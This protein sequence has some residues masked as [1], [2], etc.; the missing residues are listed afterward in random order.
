MSSVTNEQVLNKGNDE[1]KSELKNS[2]EVE[3]VEILP[4]YTKFDDFVNAGFEALKNGI[5]V[6]NSFPSGQKYDY[7]NCFPNFRN[8]VN[9]EIKN[10]LDCMQNVIG[11]TGVRGNIRRRDIE[12]K[13]ELLVEA[14]DIL[15]ERAGICMD[16]ASGILRNPDLELVVSQS[17]PVA[18]SGSW[19]NPT[20]C[21]E[22]QQ[23]KL[24]S[25]Q[26]PVIR[27]LAAKNI[28]RPQL[29]FEDKI[30]NSSNTL[31]QPR[32]SDKPNSLK[33]LALF[34]EEDEAGEYFSHPY[35]FELDRFTPAK[36]QLDPR[37]PVKYKSLDDT[38]IIMIERKEDVQI[39]LNDLRN[40][41]E[42]AVDL[43]HHSYRSFLGITCLMQ[44][45]TRDTDYLI[46]TLTLRSHLHVLNEI[47]TKPSILK[48]FHGAGSDIEWL[49]R[50][51]SLYVV[52]MF[53][54]H[55]AAKQLNL[56]YLSL[57]YLLKQHCGVDPNKHFQLADWRIR[58]L[59]EELMK[60]ARE[61][62]HYLLYIKDKL[63]NALLDQANGQSNILKAIYDRSTDI[64][65]KVYR[66]PVWTEDS[67][68]G[69]YRKSKKI[70]NNKQLYAL[71]ELHKWR[72]MISRQEDDS[73]GYVLP[74]HMLLNMAESL[75][76][77]MQGILACCNPIPPLVRQNSLWLHKIILKARE[78]PMIKPILE[79]DIRQRM[80]QRHQTTDLET[81]ILYSPHDMPQ[82]MEVRADLPCL[83]DPNRS[84]EIRPLEN[85]VPHCVTVFDSPLQ[86]EDEDADGSSRRC[87]KRTVFISPF[88]RY[89]RVLPM[90]AAE[91]AKE[92]EKQEKQE[93]D[94][95]KSL[96]KSQKETIE[97][98]ERVHEHFMNVVTAVTVPVREEQPAT[99]SSTQPAE[100]I[101]TNKKDYKS[102]SQMKGRKRKRQSNYHDDVQPTTSQIDLSTPVPFLHKKAQPNHKQDGKNVRSDTP[103]KQKPRSRSN[104]VEDV[105]HGENNVGPS[106]KAMRNNTKREKQAN[107]NNL[108]SRG[109]LPEQSFDYKN[110]DFSSFQG[111]SR[112]QNRGQLPFQAQNKKK[113]FRGNRGKGNRGKKQKWN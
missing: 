84:A 86:S 79:D 104:F 95:L 58:P 31:W 113:N 71:R 55:I 60:Y 39:L 56:P 59:P 67:C 35:E 26:S 49:Q 50:D 33:P 69:I 53:D 17:T 65:K 14:N 18:V 57:A 103:R 29:K 13:F 66:K 25:N 96:D 93:S 4:G 111:G 41:T 16:E 32:I 11:A 72:D 85:N 91:E 110:V 70:F 30:D 27:L 9:G 80:T 73:I 12:E 106:F 6:A 46:D 61:D 63:T 1:V 90:I 43:E 99:V 112:T 62:T 97:S 81:V 109:M 64:C 47:F 78:Q 74:N 76:R 52:N 23:S 108:A 40:H 21:S 34:I 75:P 44:I 88:E 5:K 48:V 8:I 105:P 15:L 94:R 89:K 24:A 51:L 107:R 92:R 102:L 36:H 28:Q 100:S 2:Q 98:I 3:V 83:L 7:Y 68:M 101:N 37:I 19:N 38:P 82:G 20:S 45:S 87:K 77:E 54:T 10:V 22:T 42:I